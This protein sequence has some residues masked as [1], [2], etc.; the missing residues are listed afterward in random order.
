MKPVRLAYDFKKAVLYATRVIARGIDT[1]IMLKELRSLLSKAYG[2]SAHKVAKA[3]VEGCKYS[4][5]NPKLIK[6]RRPFIVSEGV[7][8][9]FGNRNIRLESPNTVKI[10]YPHDIIWTIT[11]GLFSVR[12]S[13]ESTYR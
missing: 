13:V 7:A 10:K 2:D 8:S 11:Y 4:C 6:I 5:G 12:H 1:D 3:I 9:R